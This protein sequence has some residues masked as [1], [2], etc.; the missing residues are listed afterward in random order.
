MMMWVGDDKG[1]QGR[2]EK[3][4]KGTEIR[5]RGGKGCNMDILQE[6]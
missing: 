5:T 3:D 1:K 2:D 6:G 4:R